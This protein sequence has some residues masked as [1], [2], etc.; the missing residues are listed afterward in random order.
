MDEE[1]PAWRAELRKAIGEAVIAASC[2]GECGLSEDDCASEHPIRVAAWTFDVVSDIEAPV[3]WIAAVVDT[4]LVSHIK[5]AE[6]RGRREAL[7]A[8]ICGAC[9]HRVG[10]IN[11]PTGGWWAHE[12]HPSD[13]HDAMECV[14]ES[15]SP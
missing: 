8:F 2:D 9:G 13:D 11:C 10:W 7:A 15:E 14:P 5:A 1:E 6:E 4:A 3:N 12:V